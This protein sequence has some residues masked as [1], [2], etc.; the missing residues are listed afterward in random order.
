[1]KQGEYLFIGTDVTNTELT[2]W[3]LSGAKQN[4][5]KVTDIRYFGSRRFGKP[6][7]DSDIDVYITTPKGKKDFELGPLFTKRFK[8]GDKTYEIEFHAFVDWN[9]GFVPTDLI[10]NNTPSELNNA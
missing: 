4:R 1:M 5:I 2:E 9:D 8:K 3:I 6:R 7:E 10:G